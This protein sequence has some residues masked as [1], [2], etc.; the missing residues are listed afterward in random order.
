MADTVDER[1]FTHKVLTIH[2]VASL[3]VFTGPLVAFPKA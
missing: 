2:T 3:I 1:A